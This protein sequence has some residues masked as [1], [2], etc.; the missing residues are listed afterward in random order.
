M[1]ELVKR[2]LHID[3]HTRLTAA[4]VLKHQWISQRQQ[5]PHH[6]LTIQDAQLVKVGTFSPLMDCVFWEI[7]IWTDGLFV[8]GNR[9][10][11]LN[12]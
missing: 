2:M 5:L 9:Q 4:Q 6:P 3:P 1:Q 7:W 8:E 12:M 11:K 10:H